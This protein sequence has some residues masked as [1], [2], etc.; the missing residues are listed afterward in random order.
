MAKNIESILR[1][2]DAEIQSLEIY[3]KKQE[4]KFNAA[5]T[6]KERVRINEVITGVNGQITGLETAKAIVILNA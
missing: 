5:K 1:V 2:I 3:M 4:R 6:D